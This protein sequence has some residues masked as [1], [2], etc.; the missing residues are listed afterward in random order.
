MLFPNMMVQ[1]IQQFIA[2][3]M[4]VILDYH[5]QNSETQAHDLTAFVDAW[6]NVWV[7]VT[8]L[9]NF[10]SDMAGRIIL[11]IMN[12]PDSMSIRWEPQGGRPGAEQLYLAAADALWAATP[13]KVFFMFEGEP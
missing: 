6:V 1:V 4:Y 11:D 3:G 7:S 2:L 10:E 13:N 8:C 9:P 12:E 5:P